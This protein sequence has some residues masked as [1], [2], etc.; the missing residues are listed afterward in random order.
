MS[1][2]VISAPI[3]HCQSQEQMARGVKF[4]H[5][6]LHIISYEALPWIWICFGLLLFF[7]QRQLDHI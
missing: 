6:M 3:E 4:R 5:S 2:M 7:L 1:S